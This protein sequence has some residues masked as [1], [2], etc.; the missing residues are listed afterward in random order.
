MSSHDS[1][2]ERNVNYTSKWKS[3][4]EKISLYIHSWEAAGVPCGVGQFPFSFSCNSANINPIKDE[5]EVWELAHLRW[6]GKA[7]QI[8]VVNEKSIRKTDQTFH[9]AADDDDDDE[10]AGK[11]SL[12]NGIREYKQNF[13]FISSFVCIPFNLYLDS[14]YVKRWRAVVYADVSAGHCV[15]SMVSFEKYI[16]KESHASSCDM[17][18]IAFNSN[19][20]CRFLWICKSLYSI[21]MKIA[22]RSEC[23]RSMNL[24]Q[25]LA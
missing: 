12:G 10:E 6:E 11:I 20:F 25:F 22:N 13:Q 23:Q 16:S 19:M 24:K 21:Y 2:H 3:G 8:H 5:R 9:C 15:Q 1:T 14:I 7:D 4:G 18:R 17:W